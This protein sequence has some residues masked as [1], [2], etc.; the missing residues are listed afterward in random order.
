MRKGLLTCE[1]WPQLEPSGLHGFIEDG[2]HAC[3]SM[4]QL[5]SSKHS[6]MIAPQSMKNA[7]LETF[8]FFLNKKSG[9]LFC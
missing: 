5:S 2:K 9:K 1:S 8:I 6:A 4:Q 7:N 3:V